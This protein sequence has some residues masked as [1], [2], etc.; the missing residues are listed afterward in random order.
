MDRKLGAAYGKYKKWAASLF[1]QKPRDRKSKN[2]RNRIFRGIYEENISIHDPQSVLRRK[3]SKART[4]RLRRWFPLIAALVA[5]ACFALPIFMRQQREIPPAVNAGIAAAAAT[6]SAAPRSV[7]AV[8]PANPGNADEIRS[9]EISDEIPLGRMFNLGINRIVVDA[10]HGGSHPGTIGRGGTKEKDITLAIAMKLRDQLI[11]LGV[12]DVLM[13]RTGD[14]TISLQERVDYAKEAK[15]DAFISIHVNSLPNSRSNVIETFYFGPSKDRRALQLA[16]IE[17]MGSE[18]GLSDFMEIVERMGRTMK[19]QESKNLAEAIQKNLY[20]NIKELDPDARDTGVKRAP[21]VVLMELDVP[22]VLTEIACMS[23]AKSERDL[24][25]AENQE[26]IAAALA[27]GIMS[28]QNR[29]VTRNES[30]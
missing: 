27:A 4:L 11:R 7:P 2:Q 20:Q 22:S 16:D 1:F 10:G 18:H 30:R 5:L 13:T 24:N 12:T 3:A 26:R 23:N 28:Y 15:A 9:I 29:G 25:S 17:N 8:T 6:V 19:L 21:F 14:A